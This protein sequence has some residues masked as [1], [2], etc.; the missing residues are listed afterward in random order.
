ML[1]R[2][3]E[4]SLRSVSLR[5]IDNPMSYTKMDRHFPRV[6]EGISKSFHL[7]QRIVQTS[8]KFQHLQAR[9]MTARFPGINEIRAVIDR[10]YSPL[11]FRQCA[12]YRGLTYP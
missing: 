3:A 8:P 5:S 4:A 6:I 7:S 12:T 10:A 9:S 2:L 1:S 11:I